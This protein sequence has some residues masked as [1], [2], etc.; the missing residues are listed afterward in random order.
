MDCP[1]QC[2]PTSVTDDGQVVSDRF[3]FF[4]R[5]LGR[6]GS[7]TARLVSMT[8]TITYP[9]PDHDEIVARLVPWA[10]AGII[11]KDGVRPGSPYVALMLTGHHGVRLQ[12]N[13]AHDIAVAESAGPEQLPRWLQLSRSGD[14]IT[15]AESSDGDRWNV[16]GTV[17]L[18][19]LPEVVQVGLF[20][21]SPGDLT[22]RP[23][24][25]GGVIEEVRFTQAVGVFDHVTVEGS[26]AGEWRSEPVGEMNRTDWEKFHRASGAAQDDGVITVS[27]T[28]DIG[29]LGE[30]VQK[31]D[32]RLLGLVV[33]L[34]IV[35]VV[36]ARY[37]ARTARSASVARPAVLARAAI[38]GLATFVAGVVGVGVVRPVGAAMLRGNGVVVSPVPLLTEVRV[39]LGLGLVIA[40]CS[41]FAFGLG[42]WLRRGWL[43][44]LVGLA[45]TALPYAV[46]TVPLLPDAWSE[47]LLR[48]TPAGG[49]SVQ[50][51]SVAYPHVT[52]YFAPSTGYFPLP[53]WVG[54][55]LAGAHTATVL[56]I[57]LAAGRSDHRGR[58]ALGAQ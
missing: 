1:G 25:L 50:Q 41:V 14:T 35:V 12:Y 45:L 9:P 16:V 33:A 11:I 10:K 38:L 20:A 58:S 40:L 4:H 17:T 5:D 22:L 15:A 3:W 55:A 37:G 31:T 39:V 6:E 27:G 51:T 32:V 19:G 28:G 48:L 47:W 57:A 24:A 46:T 56:G 23:V 52:A 36:S 42:G 7:I 8:G 30:D 2:P 53:W 26:P 34:I 21:T 13:Y 54:L 44:S 18:A 29:P 49:L 43:A